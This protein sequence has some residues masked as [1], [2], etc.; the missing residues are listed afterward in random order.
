MDNL[1][2][3]MNVG[4]PDVTHEGKYFYPSEE[5]GNCDM[6]LVYVKTIKNSG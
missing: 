6:Y 1:P 3:G 4:Q 2:C 5:P